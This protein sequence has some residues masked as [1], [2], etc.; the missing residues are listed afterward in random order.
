MH[1][2]MTND[3]ILN[4]Y[5]YK[6]DRMTRKEMVGYMT[7]LPGDINFSLDGVTISHKSKQLYTIARGQFA[8]FDQYSDLGSDSHNH[9]AEVEDAL[10][11]RTDSL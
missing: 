5:V 11:V 7:K 3:T 8:V 6:I 2:P 10:I 4:E 9:D 1:L